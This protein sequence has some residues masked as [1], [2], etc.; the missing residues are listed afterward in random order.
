M[1]LV[2]LN[3][4]IFIRQAIQTLETPPRYYI[5]AAPQCVFP[6]ATLGSVL[7]AAVFDAVYVQFCE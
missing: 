4:E 6:D 1:L 3:R 2:L 5:T 7:N